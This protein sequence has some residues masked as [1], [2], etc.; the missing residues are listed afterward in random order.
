VC[1]D[2]G[3]ATGKR[4]VGKIDV[5]S[6]SL[7]I[8]SSPNRLMNKM[9]Y[10]NKPKWQRSRVWYGSHRDK[11]SGHNVRLSLRSCWGLKSCGIRR[12]VAERVSCQLWTRVSCQLWTRVSCQLWT[13]RTTLQRG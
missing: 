3:T 8:Q 10:K 1:T 12:S 5:G 13:D 11:D 6:N 2:R 9:E 7:M 4:T